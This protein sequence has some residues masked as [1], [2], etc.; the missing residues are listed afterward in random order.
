MASRVFSRP[1]RVAFRLSKVPQFRA[2]VASSKFLNFD[3]R[4]ISQNVTFSGR[5]SRG[6]KFMISAPLMGLDGDPPPSRQPL[7]IFFEKDLIPADLS[8]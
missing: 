7:K 1:R 6:A 8:E 4:T 2:K 5:F 3:E